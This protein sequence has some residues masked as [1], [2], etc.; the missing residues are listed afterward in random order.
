[1]LL[2]LFR[3]YVYCAMGARPMYDLILKTKLKVRDTCRTVTF[4]PRIADNVYKNGFMA[5]LMGSTSTAVQAY[6]SPGM[7]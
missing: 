5:E 1:M 6:T 2:F 4:L 3:T 7:T